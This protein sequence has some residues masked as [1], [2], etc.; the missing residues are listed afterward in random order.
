MPKSNL[1]IV[2]NYLDGVRPFVISGWTPES[3][4]R[5]EGETWR[6]N[7]KT[8][9]RKNGYNQVIDN[10]GKVL[11][12]T[13]QECSICKKNMRMFADRLDNKIFPRTGRCYEC[14]IDFE[15]KLKKQ[16]KYAAY[17][18]EKILTYKKGHLEEMIN[19]IQEA[20]DFLKKNKET[21]VFY[22]TDGTSEQWTDESNVKQE[23]L[24]GAKKDIKM[25]KK[26][27]A[28]TIKELDELKKA[29]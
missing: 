2:Q 27:L 26:E 21:P 3:V 18:K 19:K 24:K 29:S 28:A 9:I 17:E 11:D 25:V 20:I 22:N 5:K 8:W 10:R 16:G 23:L 14:N 15:A 4:E 1:E 13:R 6:S 7:G 12:M